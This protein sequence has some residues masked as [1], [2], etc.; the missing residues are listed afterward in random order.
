MRWLRFWGSSGDL[1]GLYT[2]TCAK[3]IHVNSNEN[4]SNAKREN[5]EQLNKDIKKI[6]R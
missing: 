6:G 4:K 3:N 1:E 2:G 5:V